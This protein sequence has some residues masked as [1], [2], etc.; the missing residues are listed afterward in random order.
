MLATTHHIV[1]CCCAV[2]VQIRVVALITC[3]ST[4]PMCVAVSACPT[5]LTT[6]MTAYY[7][8][9]TMTTTSIKA[10]PVTASLSMSIPP[11]TIA[12]FDQHLH[13]LCLE[14]LL[15]QFKLNKLVRLKGLEIL[16]MERFCQG[17]FVLCSSLGHSQMF[18]V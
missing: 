6:P 12:S 14:C 10:T 16:L 9:A 4:I 3:M 1:K 15:Y 7:A 5:F 2:V 17:Y 13:C 8:K 18:W 11:M